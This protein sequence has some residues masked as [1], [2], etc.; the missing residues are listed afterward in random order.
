[1]RR[2]AHPQRKHYDGV[3]FADFQFKVQSSMFK[4]RHELKR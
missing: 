4:V 2:A 3:S 1:M